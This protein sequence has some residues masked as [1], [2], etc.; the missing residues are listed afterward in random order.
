MIPEREEKR[1]IPADTQTAGT[2]RRTPRGRRRRKEG[3]KEETEKEK[4]KQR[5][6][7]FMALKFEGLVKGGAYLFACL[8]S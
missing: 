1:K 7:Q 8:L 4:K 6:R 5:F 3:R 2:D